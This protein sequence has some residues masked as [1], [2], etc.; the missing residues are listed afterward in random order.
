MGCIIKLTA[1][2]RVLGTMATKA[3]AGGSEVITLRDS[4]GD[5]GYFAFSYS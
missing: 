1:F 2:K 5:T 3:T 4:A